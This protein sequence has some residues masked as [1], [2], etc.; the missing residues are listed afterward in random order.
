MQKIWKQDLMINRHK[1]LCL[2]ANYSLIALEACSVTSQMVLGKRVLIDLYNN[3]GEI[4]KIKSRYLF[5]ILIK[6]FIFM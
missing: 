4:L 6:M 5:Q 2:Q 1:N 3:I